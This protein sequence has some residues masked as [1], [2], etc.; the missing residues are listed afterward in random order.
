[1]NPGDSGFRGR[2]VGRGDVAGGFRTNRPHVPDFFFQAED[3][4]RAGRVTGV[5][6]CALPISDPP[7]NQLPT[8][9]SA[10]Q[11]WPNSTATPVRTAS[12]PS[13]SARPTDHTNKPAAPDSPSRQ[14]LNGNTP[15]RSPTV[16]ITPSSS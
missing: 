12:S 15:G 10:H 9:G 6:T 1:M 4:I 11:T 5:Q 2:G 3:G 7:A 8:S 13:S 14:T 16:S